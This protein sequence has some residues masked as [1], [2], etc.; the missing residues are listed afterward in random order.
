MVVT[1]ITEIDQVGSAAD[2]LRAILACRRAL[3]AQLVAAGQED[4]SITSKSDPA[5]VA[6]VLL[7]LLQGMR[8]VGKAALFPEK[9]EDFVA[10]A[11]KVLD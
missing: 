5:R 8:V 11:L 6:D 1:G 10:L 4:G 9:A 2:R 3:L 7:T